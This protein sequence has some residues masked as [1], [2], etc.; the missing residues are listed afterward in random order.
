MDESRTLS[1]PE[2]RA[3][4]S[5]LAESGPTVGKVQSFV[6]LAE[7]RR[8]LGRLATTELVRM[9]ATEKFA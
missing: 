4:V 8:L 1:N 3:A 2:D 5:S 6:D 7:L 9:I